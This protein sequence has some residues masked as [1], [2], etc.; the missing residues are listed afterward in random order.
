MSLFFFG[1]H[2]SGIGVA[3]LLAN[4]TNPDRTNTA[5]AKAAGDQVTYLLKN[6]PRT[7]SGAI[8]HRA[9]EVQLW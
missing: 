8:S 1:T 7:A 4:W 6:T 5:Y 9:N 2:L 3:V